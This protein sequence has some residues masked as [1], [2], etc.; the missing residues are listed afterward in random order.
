[1]TAYLVLQVVHRR[2]LL[3][4]APTRAWWVYQAAL[5]FAAS[6]EE[7][8]DKIFLVVRLLYKSIV[9]FVFNLYPQ[10]RHATTIKF[11]IKDLSSFELY[12]KIL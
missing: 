7:V 6:L 5:F 4:S 12:T 10:I 8:F 11:M 2:I 9:L 3:L 1:M